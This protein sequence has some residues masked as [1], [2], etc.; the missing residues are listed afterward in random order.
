MQVWMQVFQRQ[1]CEESTLTNQSQPDK[2]RAA[3]CLAVSCQC[4]RKE[5]LCLLHSVWVNVW[6]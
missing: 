4:L 2:E 1:E 3:L 6:F 5:E